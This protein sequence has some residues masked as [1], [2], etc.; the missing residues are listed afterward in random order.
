MKAIKAIFHNDNSYQ[1]EK[2]ES[3]IAI[4]LA[5]LQISCPSDPYTQV[6]ILNAMLDSQV[7]EVHP[8]FIE[9]TE[10]ALG[11][12]RSACQSVIEVPYISI[13]LSSK[14]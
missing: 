12:L 13:P 7:V 2:P 9:M 11:K 3:L 1:T 4:L 14:E 5:F 8:I 6:T 10:E